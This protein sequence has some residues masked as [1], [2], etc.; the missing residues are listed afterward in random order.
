MEVSLNRQ[1]IEETWKYFLVLILSVRIAVMQYA[2]C[3]Q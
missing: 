3:M 1:K 2:D